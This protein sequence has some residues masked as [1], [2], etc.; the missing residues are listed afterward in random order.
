MTILIV[1]ADCRAS[2]PLASSLPIFNPLRLRSARG[3]GS[4]P[5]IECW[6]VSYGSSRVGRLGGGITVGVPKRIFD[7]SHGGKI[8]IRILCSSEDLR[9]E[10]EV[11]LLP[12]DRCLTGI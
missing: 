8:T 3:A 5:K 11:T 1:K 9:F 7:K 12:R 4:A 6:I 10:G 2:A